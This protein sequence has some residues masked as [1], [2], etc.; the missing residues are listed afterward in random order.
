LACAPSRLRRIRSKNVRPLDCPGRLR[1]DAARIRRK[2]EHAPAG[3]TFRAGSGTARDERTFR[4]PLNRFLRLI[5][6]VSRNSR[7]ENNMFKTLKSRFVAG[8]IFLSLLIVA[9]AAISLLKA[10]ELVSAALIARLNA[11]EASFY[12]ALEQESLRAFSMAEIV[13]RD[14]DIIDAFAAK[15]RAKLQQR[16]GASFVELKANHSIE[17]AHFHLPPAISF[18]RLHKPEKYGDNISDRKTVVVANQTRQPVRGIE[19]GQGGLGFRAVVPVTK[20]GQHIGTFE[21]GVSFG[22]AMVKKLAAA[23]Q[24]DAGIYFARDGKFD[25]LGTVFPEGFKPSHET[26]SGALHDAQFE[27]SVAVGGTRMAMRSVPIHDFAGN[28]VAVAVFGVGRR[29]FQEMLN[30]NLS[31]IGTVTL[32]AL[33]LLAGMAL[34]FLRGVVRPTAKLVCDMRRLASG[35]LSAEPGAVAGDDEIGDMCRA[36]EVFRANAVSRAALEQQQE[37]EHRET[38]ARRDRVDR[39]ICSFRSDAEKAL[40]L[41]AANAKDMAGTAARLTGIAAGTSEKARSAASFSEE[42]SANVLSVAA[43]TEQLSKSIAEIGLQ[44]SNTS[45]NLSQANKC[46]AATNEKVAV[47]SSATQHIGEVVTLI[48]EIAAQTNLLALNASIE[49]ARA[50]EAG[51]GFSVVASE[52]KHLSEQTAKATLAISE[53]IGQV[54]TSARETAVSIGEIAAMIGEVDAF[55]ESIAAAIVEQESATSD[56]SNSIHM[57]ADGT[58]R[59]TGNVVGVTSAAGDTS[60]A[61]QKVQTA[62]GL[63]DN[64]AQDLKSRIEN[65]LSEVEAA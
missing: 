7:G 29:Q 23:M 42:A 53:T 65:F 12:S 64:A 44:V 39:L 13:A 41:L 62:S 49:A 58:N 10:N 32:T 51:R 52:V 1:G 33:V 20:D 48:Q 16:L 6:Y 2:P 17:Q 28:T 3:I 14:P 8:C 59:V 15:D 56:I 31:R 22:G 25:P 46:A 30:S 38:R 26:L 55:A 19:T 57:A 4:L 60:A 43:A 40:A 36:V 37:R 45:Q 9:V 34:A 50:G 21:Y 47:L 61:A 63:V 27:P 11:A 24:A 35:D 18:L 5:A 54:Q